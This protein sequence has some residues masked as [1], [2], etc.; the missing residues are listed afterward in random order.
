M[1][2]QYRYYFEAKTKKIFLPYQSS[3]MNYDKTLRQIFL[4]VI[5][6]LIICIEINNFLLARYCVICVSST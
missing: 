5:R 3:L 6:R 4:H 1:S 2:I